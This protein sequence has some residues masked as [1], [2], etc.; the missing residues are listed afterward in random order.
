MYRVCSQIWLNYFLDD[1]H[2][3]SITKSLSRWTGYH[4]HKRNEWMSHIWLEVRHKLDL[5]IYSCLVLATNKNY[6]SK[7]GE[8]WLFSFQN[9]ANFAGFFLKK[10]SLYNL[11]WVL[12]FGHH[13]VKIRQKIKHC[14]AVPFFIIILAKCHLK[15]TQI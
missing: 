1:C 11:H 6:L 12:F 7:Y 14:Q 3:V 10:K 8:M 4:Q 13:S 15:Q 5:K 9:M 2:F